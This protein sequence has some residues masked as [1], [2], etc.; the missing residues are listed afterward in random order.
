MTTQD[1]QTDIPADRLHVWRWC[2]NG[3]PLTREQRDAVGSSHMDQALVYYGMKEDPAN[4]TSSYYGQVAAHLV[5]HLTGPPKDTNPKTLYGQA[6]P[7]LGLLPGAAQVAIAEVLALGKAKYGDAN[8]RVDPVSYSTYHNAL[9][10]HLIKAWEGEEMDPESGQP[11]LAHVAANAMIL[12]D[13]KAC[14]TLI[15]DRPPQGA[16]SKAIEQNTRQVKGVV[17]NG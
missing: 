3:K 1:N 4:V 12:L 14:G 13:A 2:E 5:N 16:V 15:D 7:S 6:K 8:W 9:L 10:R 17:S 11:H